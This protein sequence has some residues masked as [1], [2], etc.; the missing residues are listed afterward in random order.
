MGTHAVRSLGKYDVLPAVHIWPEENEHR[1]LPTTLVGGQEPAEELRLELIE[2][3]HQIRHPVR[4][5][6]GHDSPGASSNFS[7]SVAL[8]GSISPSP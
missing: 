5:G 8:A 7:S 4:L 6:I 2:P 3:V 1:G